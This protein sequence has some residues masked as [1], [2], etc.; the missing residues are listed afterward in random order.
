M[1][2]VRVGEP[3]PAHVRRVDH[4]GQRRDEVAVGQPEA[5]VDDDR[6]GGVDHEGVDRQETEAGHLDVVVEDGDVRVSAVDVHVFSLVGRWVS[7]RDRS[8]EQA[9][10][11]AAAGHDAAELDGVQCRCTGRRCRCAIRRRSGR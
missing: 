6:L 9:V 11:G 1:V 2:A 4:L 5:G 7:E 8:G 3:D 10:G